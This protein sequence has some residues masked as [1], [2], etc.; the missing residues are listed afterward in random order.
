MNK[1]FPHEL[2][3]KLIFLLA[4]LVSLVGVHGA[5]VPESKIISYISPSTYSI[6][7]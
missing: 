6:P 7:G 3:F 5:T 4:I 1:K 2:T